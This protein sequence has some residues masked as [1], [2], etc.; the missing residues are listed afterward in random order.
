MRLELASHEL[1]C[2]SIYL[3]LLFGSRIWCQK[4]Y[5]CTRDANMIRDIWWLLYTLL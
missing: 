1:I 4:I 5:F 3:S 2:Y